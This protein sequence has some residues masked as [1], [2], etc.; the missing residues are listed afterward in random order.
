MREQVW[1]HR[2]RLH[3]VG[4]EHLSELPFEKQ[5]GSA[6]FEPEEEGFLDRLTAISL[7]RDPAVDTLAPK[8]LEDIVFARI[9]G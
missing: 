5:G 7:V 1:I 3:L 8:E 4:I 2:G 6:S 9:D